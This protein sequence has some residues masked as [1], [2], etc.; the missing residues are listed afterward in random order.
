MAVYWGDTHLNVHEEH[1][2]SL[3]L[4]LEE[5]RQHLD[6]LMLAYYPADYYVMPEGLK[7]ESMGMKPRYSKSWSR[8]LHLLAECNRPGEFLTFPGYEWTGDRRRFG[9]VNVFFRGD[10]GELDLTDSLLDLYDNLREK[11]V[12]IVPHHTAYQPGERGKN[13]N[14][15]DSSLSPVMEIYSAHGSSEGS[16]TPYPMNRNIAMGPRSTP[17]TA[18]SALA[19]GLQLGFIASGDS[20]YNY[21]GVWGTGLAAVQAD[22]LSRKSLWEAF[23]KRRVYAVT[24]DRI[25]LD[26]RLND[27]YMGETVTTRGQMDIQVVVEGSDA[28]DR[29]ELVRDGRIINTHCHA[30]TWPDSVPE[31]VRFKLRAEFG[32]GPKASKGYGKQERI[33]NG[34]LMT[35]GGQILSNEGCFTWPGQRIERQELKECEFRLVTPNTGGTVPWAEI[36]GPHVPTTIGAPGNQAIVFEIEMPSAETAILKVA[37]MNI[38]IKAGEVLAGSRIIPLLDESKDLTERIF[39]IDS[40]DIESP[41]SFYFNAWKIKIHQ[42]YP[43]SAYKVQHSFRDKPG[44]GSHHYYIRVS[45]LNGQMAWSSPIWVDCA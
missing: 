3:D 39:R 44:R 15:H 24:G 20:H 37:G 26:M 13:W 35:P 29:I 6:F 7:V 25:L 14:F 4:A 16:R 21:P 41:D 17:G 19:Q 12:L 23:F 2:D 33:W 38:K 42:A 9:D 45:Q 43:E 11:E 32:W 22:E 5:G 10:Q 36:A 18:R 1:I 30:D 27:A 31:V 34:R 40:R 8:I 28:I